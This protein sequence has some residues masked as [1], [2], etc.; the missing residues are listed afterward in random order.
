MKDFLN[1]QE[2]KSIFKKFKENMKKGNK[3]LPK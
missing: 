3:I 2:I 1:F